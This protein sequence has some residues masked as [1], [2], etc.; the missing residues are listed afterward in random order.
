MHLQDVRGARVSG[1]H[2]QSGESRA[3]V[4]RAGAL[5]LRAPADV[6]LEGT[7][8]P[9][10]RQCP[11]RQQPPRAHAHRLHRALRR[12]DALPAQCD[13]TSGGRRRTSADRHVLESHASASAP[14]G[15][16]AD[17]ARGDATAPTQV[18]VDAVHPHV[19][20]QV[21]VAA[22]P[23]AFVLS[24]FFLVSYLKFELIKSWRS[25]LQLMLTRVLLVVD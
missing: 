20:P 10:P 4:S 12:G 15:D 19:R 3:H 9:A 22:T 24:I 21:R 18:Q 11:S 23:S 5:L 14:G 2:Q 7:Q 25:F 8:P 17:A 6:P 13:V 16:A 1:E